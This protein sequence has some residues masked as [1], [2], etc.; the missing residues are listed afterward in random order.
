M[1]DQNNVYIP[2]PIHISPCT[3]KSRLKLSKLSDRGTSSGSGGKRIMHSR[4]LQAL[5]TSEPLSL[6]S[7]MDNVLSMP[8]LAGLA[9]RPSR[10]LKRRHSSSSPCVR[11]ET[12]KRRRAGSQVSDM[13]LLRHESSSDFE[14][15]L[16]EPQFAFDI[17]EDGA[18]DDDKEEGY[19]SDTGHSAT[20]TIYP[21]ADTHTSSSSRRNP[22]PHSI[23]DSVASPPTFKESHPNKSTSKMISGN[24]F[25]YEDPWTAVGVMLGIEDT[26][27]TPLKKRDFRKVLA[28]IPTPLSTPALGE[29]ENYDLDDGDEVGASRAHTGGVLKNSNG[30]HHSQSSQTSGTAG[31]PTSNHN[32]DVSRNRGQN[33]FQIFSP[34]T[35]SKPNLPNIL[36]W[37]VPYSS[38]TSSRPPS[39][40][41]RA[42]RTP[43]RSF[44]P[45]LSSN[46][47]RD[48]S[49]V[50]CV[51]NANRCNPA[52][53]GIT[54]RTPLFSP[55]QGYDSGNAFTAE[56]EW[57]DPSSVDAHI[58]EFDGDIASD[59]RSLYEATHQW[60]RS[61]SPLF[62][63]SSSHEEMQRRGG[64]ADWVDGNGVND[65]TYHSSAYY[66]SQED[67]HAIQDQEEADDGNSLPSPMQFASPSNGLDSYHDTF[68]PL[69]IFSQENDRTHIRAPDMKQP[70]PTRS[71]SYT[72]NNTLLYGS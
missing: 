6:R 54:P 11:E 41:T 23:S 1:V 16:A 71:P 20:W 42:P 45:G 28:A 7:A 38:D 53:S 66:P 72:L 34:A 47:G 19:S 9:R 5:D 50:R 55:I 60:S 3:P 48:E 21:K 59:P 37:L 63:Y 26:P 33:P 44:S 22:E 52:G 32:V 36:H 67:E 4:V 17:P 51:R 30:D 62:G 39:S 64:F 12:S 68:A 61:E 69:N 58:G 15:G 14:E 18:F 40:P 49:T 2:D 35:Q 57:E 13:D 10:T 24:I 25:D 43:Y 8:D 65:I 27:Q 56:H 31:L 29:A 46:P 70:S